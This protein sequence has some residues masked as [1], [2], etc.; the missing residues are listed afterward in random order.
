MTKEGRYIGDLPPEERKRLLEDMTLVQEP[1]H[2]GEDRPFTQTEVNEWRRGLLQDWGYSKAD[3]ERRLAGMN[4]EKNSRSTSEPPAEAATQPLTQAK[5][6]AW[7]SGLLQNWGYSS[8]EAERR[9]QGLWQPAGAPDREQ[10][11]A[12]LPEAAADLA[13]PELQAQP[14]ETPFWPDEAPY[15]RNNDPL[16]YPEEFDW[17]R[18][19]DEQIEE[20]ARKSQ[21]EQREILSEML[22]GM[23][24]LKEA[25][26]RWIAPSTGGSLAEFQAI[27]NEWHAKH[28][29]TDQDIFHGDAVTGKAEPWPYAIQPGMEPKT[30]QS[31]RS[32]QGPHGEQLS[33]EVLKGPVGFHLGTHREGEA[34]SR[35]SVEY[36]PTEAAARAALETGDWTANRNLD[37]PAQGFTGGRNG[38]EASQGRPRGR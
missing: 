35:A 25:E 15:L 27:A 19:E 37:Q 24:T 17:E 26:A 8:E 1:W 30:G 33:I 23:I 16:N 6:V 20:F 28:K 38:L 31:P 5:F 29:D 22:D 21:A 13:G 7:R 12:A 2:T 10:F 9:L 14:G 11:R 36:W 4:M 3:A 18:L 32:A 34:P